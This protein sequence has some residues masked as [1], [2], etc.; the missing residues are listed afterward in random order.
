MASLDSILTWGVI[1]ASLGTG[2][3]LYKAGYL[4]D[5]FPDLDLPWIGGGGGNGEPEPNPNPQPTPQPNTGAYSY[6]SKRKVQCRDNHLT[7]NWIASQN[8]HVLNWK[9]F[10]DGKIYPAM[11]GAPGPLTILIAI[12]SQD[13]SSASK[14]ASLGFIQYF[15]PPTEPNPTIPIPN[16]PSSSNIAMTVAYVG[17]SVAHRAYK[18][19]THAR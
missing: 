6:W 5:I 9:L 3:Y 7:F 4:K 14:L 8:I 17:Q 15:A 10:N 1:G 2:V 16:P 13:Q 18:V 11:C 19:Y 12:D